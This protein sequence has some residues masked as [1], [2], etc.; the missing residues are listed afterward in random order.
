V[1]GLLSED[2]QHRAKKSEDI[3]EDFETG[4]SKEIA[5]NIASWLNRRILERTDDPAKNQFFL[6]GRIGQRGWGFKP[7]NDFFYLERSGQ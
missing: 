2:R 5:T 7:T 1:S 3:A 6:G 4:R